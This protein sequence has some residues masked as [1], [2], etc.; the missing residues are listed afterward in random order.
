MTGEQDPLLGSRQP[1]LSGEGTA[2]FRIP[3]AGGPARTLGDLPAFITLRGGGYFFL[4]GLRALKY[5]AQ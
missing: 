3:T 1:L 2:G 5:I 4:P